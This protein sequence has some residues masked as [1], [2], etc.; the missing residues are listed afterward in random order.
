MNPGKN[1][2]APVRFTENQAPRL[3]FCDTAFDYVQLISAPVFTQH[4]PADVLYEWEWEWGGG[5]VLYRC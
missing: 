2:A 5:A 3:S 4:F 1:T